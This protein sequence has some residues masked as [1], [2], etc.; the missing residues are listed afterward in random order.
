MF[1]KKKQ[2]VY[3]VAQEELGGI[4][5]RITNKTATFESISEDWKVVYSIGTQAY[6]TIIAMYNAGNKSDLKVI[7]TTLYMQEAFFYP[8]KDE[9]FEAGFIRLHKAIKAVL[10]QYE[11]ENPKK[12]ISKEEDDKILEEE[13]LKHI[14]MEEVKNG[15]S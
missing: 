9:E 10:A 1:K 12:E 7:G 13:R 15:R 6:L 3:L 14:K 8:I 2:K 5:L 11:K 4:R